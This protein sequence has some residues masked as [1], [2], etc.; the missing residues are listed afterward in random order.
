MS[1]KQVWAAIVD[2]SHR[3][4]SIVWRYGFIVLALIFLGLQSAE[5]QNPAW[6][7]L[8]YV[9]TEKTFQRIA[10]GIEIFCDSTGQRSLNDILGEQ[11]NFF[12][13]KQLQTNRIN[14]GFTS[15]AYWMRF[16]LQDSLA[17]KWFLLFL[18]TSYTDSVECFVQMPSG[19][20][21]RSVSGNVVPLA[22]RDIAWRSAAFRLPVGT[23]TLVLMRFSGKWIFSNEPA[24]MTEAQIQFHIQKE[25]FIYGIFVGIVLALS[26]YNFFLYLRLR[27]Q[28]TGFY[29]LYILFF[30]IHALV[31][32]SLLYYE[33]FPNVAPRIPPL[34]VMV[35]P[36]I[37]GAYLAFFTSEFL[38]LKN[39]QPRLWLIN[40]GLA[41]LSIALG[42]IAL[43]AGFWAESLGAVIFPISGVVGLA[44][45]GVITMSAVQSI[46]Q[47]EVAGRYFLAATFIFL[48]SMVVKMLANLNVITL[49]YGAYYGTV[50][51]FVLQLLLF[52]FALADRIRLLQ[53][54][55]MRE[56]ENARRIEQESRTEHEKN[57]E[58]QRANSEIAA[59]KL[60]LEDQ[61]L[62]IES[63]NLELQQVNESLI[64][65]QHLL[66]EQTRDAERRNQEL[67]RSH[68]EVMR[69]N[70]E[71][72]GQHD[73]LSYQ[74]LVLEVAH[75]E[76][77]FANESIS[78]QKKAVE[79]KQKAIESANYEL[80]AM[81]AELLRQQ[82]LLEEQ[83]VETEMLNT[84]LQERNNELRIL[85]E[86]R[87]E[88]LGIV[89]H[90]LKNPIASIQG[91]AEILS[92]DSTVPED[93]RTAMIRL[94]VQNADRMNRLVRNL[95]DVNAIERGGVIPTFGVL[96]VSF[97]MGQTISNYQNRA[98]QKDIRLF[99]YNDNPVFA[100]ADEQMMM[101]VAD[102]LVSNA[103]KYSPRGKAVHIT[104]DTY[105]SPTTAAEATDSRDT[106]QRF[107]VKQVA[108]F[109]S[110]PLAVIIVQDEGQGI[111]PEEMPR[112][113]GK[114]SRLSTRPT[115]DEDSTGLGLSIVK[116]L[117]ESMQGTIWCESEVGVGS[118]FVMVLPLEPVKNNAFPA[119]KSESVK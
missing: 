100:I 106:A 41:F 4:L 30:S 103:V 58:L 48:A 50:V 47:K 80:Q 27:D 108:E 5:A 70:Q 92:T 15:S 113:F 60:L 93:R 9:S 39:S 31:F 54:N 75:R 16:H 46:R 13:M 118:K 87:S 45:T 64:A 94:I 116:K 18:P 55:L 77:L 85:S 37:A 34:S 8:R 104:V 76:L 1:L 7:S 69:R 115:A 10:S 6:T 98:A 19:E 97:V 17:R 36:N 119:S 28:A 42:G 23:E 66:E 25:K 99:F 110:E 91:L 102:N 59:Q 35:L 52:S 56:S 71:I 68:A 86:E 11:K 88:L 29:L 114:F 112:L 101:Q 40:T 65:Q 61:K 74:K 3:S 82:Y 62:F 14:F 53:N 33:I 105:Q 81:N 38:L 78:E 32:D 2:S 24:I 95:L 73:E 109:R 90:D 21:Q 44:A 96:D 12:S 84:E 57:E 49:G 63:A 111:P 72:S 20:W 89:S 83:T 51:G 79:E 22:A 26:L 67:E 107:G 117:V 43:G